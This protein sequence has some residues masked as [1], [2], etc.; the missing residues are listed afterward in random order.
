MMS[1]YVK[2]FGAIAIS[3]SIAAGCSGTASDSD[4][5]AKTKALVEQLTAENKQLKEQ[6]SASG[7]EVNASA[8]G[9]ATAK[10]GPSPAATKMKT[11]ESGTPL[12]IN[13]YA[14]ITLVKTD[15][16]AKVVPPKP[17]SLY[18]YYEVKDP[19]NIYLDTVIS[20]KSLKSSAEGAD[21]FASVAVKYADKYDYK[22]FSTIEKGGGSDFTYTN[23]TS[24]EPLKTGTLHYLAELPKE[25]SADDKSVVLTIT[26]NK[27]K[28]EYKVK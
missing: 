28:Y 23:I 1:K 21:E 12:T 27:E 25:A 11:I 24:I 4:E 22:S 6:L 16:T 19:A 5:L 3:A 26:V 15:F 9:G 20:I 14:E 2:V 17:A 10:P 7:K 18:T 8:A 13:D